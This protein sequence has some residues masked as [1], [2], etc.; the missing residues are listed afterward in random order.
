VD[1][2]YGEAGLDWFIYTASG[3]LADSL[4]GQ[5]NWRAAHAAV[6][7]GTVRTRVRQPGW[8][9]RGRVTGPMNGQW[10]GPLRPPRGVLEE[11]AACQERVP[12]AS[13][14]PTGNYHG[15][16]LAR[17]PRSGALRASV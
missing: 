1:R 9:Q 6:R 11:G 17:A 16:G 10:L 12:E 4:A 13:A 5:G 14:E 2:L 8:P 15:S 7:A 3:P